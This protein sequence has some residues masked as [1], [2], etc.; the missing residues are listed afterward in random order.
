MLDWKL[1]SLHH[2]RLFVAEWCKHVFEQP[3]GNHYVGIENEQKVG[4]C[5]LR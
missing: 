2:T 3:W 5:V 4:I 1:F